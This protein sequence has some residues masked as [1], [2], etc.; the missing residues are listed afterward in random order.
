M[1]M[2]HREKGYFT[3]KNIPIWPNP[4]IFQWTHSDIEKVNHEETVGIYEF[5]TRG[6]NGTKGNYI[7]M[8]KRKIKTQIKE[9]KNEL[10]EEKFATA[11]AKE[12]NK[13]KITIH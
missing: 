8:T 6:K 11:I 12:T 2:L 1:F 10:K 9:H 4:N 13:E 5:N 7:G 3:L